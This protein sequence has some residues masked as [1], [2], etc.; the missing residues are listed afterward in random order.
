MP[1][2]DEEFDLAGIHTYPLSSR[3]SKARVQDFA[4][5]CPPNTTIAQ[6]LDSL[7][8][9][10]AAAGLQHSG[11]RY[12]QGSARR[13]CAPGPPPEALREALRA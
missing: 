4:R 11:A 5:P 9:A 10:L 1:F 12:R 2:P 3:K 13:K 6:L 7:P 8:N